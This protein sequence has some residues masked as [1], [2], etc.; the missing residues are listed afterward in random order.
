MCT[1][2][3]CSACFEMLMNPMSVFSRLVY[4]CSLL[5]HLNHH[6]PGRRRICIP[7]PRKPP[8]WCV[9]FNISL[10]VRNVR[11]ADIILA[12]TPFLT[13]M[14]LAL[15]QAARGHGCCRAESRKEGVEQDRRLPT[16]TASSRPKLPRKCWTSSVSGIRADF[17]IL[18][19]NDDG[20]GT[21]P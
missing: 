12:G 8:W 9:V 20:V 14:K 6:S 5:Y 16:K 3:P 15:R 13:P 4:V 11:I 19:A 18:Q 7:P 17:L 10:S 2:F 21:S 1:R